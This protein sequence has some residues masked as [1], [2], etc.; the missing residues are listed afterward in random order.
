MS[1]VKLTI[2]RAVAATDFTLFLSLMSRT[3]F[4][5]NFS[6]QAPVHTIKSAFHTV[7]VLPNGIA[8]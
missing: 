7:P 3:N 2:N 4:F 5:T 8:E 1:A 6:L